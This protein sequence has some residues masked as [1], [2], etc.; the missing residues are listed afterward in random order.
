M[1]ITFAS[2]PAAVKSIDRP[3]RS[4]Y[5]ITTLPLITFHPERDIL[6]TEAASFAAWQAEE[7]AVADQ[8]SDDYADE[9][10]GL[11]L[12]ETRI[13]SGLLAW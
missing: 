7:D 10:A 9:M 6:D 8:W 3:T 2:V 5:S 12:A 4:G 11:A 1:P 13:E